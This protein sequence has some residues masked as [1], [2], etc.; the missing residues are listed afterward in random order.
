[1]PQDFSPEGGIVTISG[2][3]ATQ[4]FTPSIAV[5]HT[6][7][8][9]VDPDGAQGVFAAVQVVN[10]T[11][12]MELR[13]P[14]HGTY[15]IS[16]GEQLGQVATMVAADGG[17]R[18]LGAGETPPEGAQTTTLQSVTVAETY[19]SKGAP[20]AAAL[21]SVVGRLAIRPI[22]HPN[23]V[24]LASGMQLELLFDGQPFPNMPFVLYAAGDPEADLDRVFVTDASGRATLTFDQP[25]Q[26]V[27][28]VRHRAAAGAN[29]Q[30][31]VQSFT[32][33]LTFEVQTALPDYPT[34]PVEEN[35]P[36][37]RNLLERR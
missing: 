10:P 2:A 4:F 26:Y 24:L 33:S 32:T 28:A 34:P 5:A 1:M 15:R 6:G 19:V 13:V 17:W 3:F 14:G 11:T 21:Q 12:T 23:Q 8:H 22:T 31:Q 35:R 18:A 30:A 29:A 7:V 37:R 25:G 16:T 27:V 36:R 20:N 9:A